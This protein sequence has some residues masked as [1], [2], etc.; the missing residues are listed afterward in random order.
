MR[1]ERRIAL[2]RSAAAAG[3]VEAP[4]K[5]FLNDRPSMIGDTVVYVSTEEDVGK[6]RQGWNGIYST[7]F[8]TSV[9]K[10]LSP[11]GVTDYSPAVSPSGKSLVRSCC[12]RC[13]TAIA[14]NPINFLSILNF[15]TSI[16]S[17]SCL[18]IA[19]IL[20][21]MSISCQLCQIPVNC[22]DNISA[23]CVNCVN[24]VNHVTCLS[25]L[26]QSCQMSVNCVDNVKS[27][28]I[29]SSVSKKAGHAN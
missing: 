27:L 20:W 22:V 14:S 4:P 16:N 9:T 18:S 10:R 17:V 21:M 29:V 6:P 3:T 11:P 1:G 24:H 2:R 7:N 19:P 15:V 25:T 5:T 26:C 12:S 23:S 8:R 13:I 28:S